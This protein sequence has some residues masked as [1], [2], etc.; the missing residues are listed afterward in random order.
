MTGS[1]DRLQVRPLEPVAG[2]PPPAAFLSG[3]PLETLS[4]DI[5]GRR[6]TVRAVCNQQ[7]LL[8]ASEQFGTFP[9]GLL[10]WESAP[11][12]AVALAEHT[13]L[14]AGR[15]VLELGAGAGLAGLVASQLGAASVRQT[16]HATEALALARMNAALNGIEGVD[17]QFAD[18]N[19]WSDETLY[20]LIIGSD[21]LYEKQVHAP[22]SAILEHNLAPGGRVM[23]TD[24]GRMDTPAF[25]DRLEKAGWHVTYREHTVAAFAPIEA[26]ARVRIS[27][28]EARRGTNARGGHR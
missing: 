5:A 1:P 19:D 9:F 14:V 24:P 2:S 11:A 12:L 22:L 25:V 15:R 10:L 8:E 6:W 20:D 4:F 17:A 13:E 27:L 18:W 26:G 3:V 28:I 21:V 7:A 16:D 23:L